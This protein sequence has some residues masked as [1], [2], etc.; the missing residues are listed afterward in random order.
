MTILAQPA[1][2]VPAQNPLIVDLRQ[3]IPSGEE[4]VNAVVTVTDVAT[5]D[6]VAFRRG[7]DVFVDDTIT[8]TA[9]WRIDL[10][11]IVQTFF[12]SSALLWGFGS[13]GAGYFSDEPELA[14][15]VSFS[16]RY[17]K[18]NTAGLLVDIGVE[19]LST[20]FIALNAGRQWGEAFDLADFTVATGRRLLSNAPLVRSVCLTGGSFVSYWSENIDAARV[21]LYDA[22][23]AV[24]ADEYADLAGYTSGELV[25][26][27]VGP[28]NL[29]NFGAW[30]TAPVTIDNTVA[31]YVV[32]FGKRSGVFPPTLAPAVTESLTFVVR[33]CCDYEASVYWLNRL[34]GVDSY[35]F[36]GGRQIESDAEAAQYEKYLSLTY[37]VSDY[38]RQKFDSREG[39]LWTL[40]TGK[41]TT[42][43]SEW[44]RELNTS[45][46]VWLL[47]NGELFAAVVLDARNV[48]TDSD[49]PVVVREYVLRLS[50]DSIIQNNV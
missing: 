6:T 31:R 26:F 47:K 33:D 21:T 41:L 8:Y 20:E 43:L 5:G 48:V 28:E 38:G 4:L 49:N 22:A 1:G 25:V 17:E 42:E 23:G 34:G 29:N 13:P 14:R 40:T 39:E 16:V 7:L 32:T 50:V 37:N 15:G 35:T 36:K 3:T 11:Q 45:T 27:G 24:L 9:D 30:L 10:R 44:L 2:L 12:E 18:K 46:R 19:D